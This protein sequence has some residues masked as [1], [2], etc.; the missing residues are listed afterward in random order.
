MMHVLAAAGDGQA[1]RAYVSSMGGEGDVGHE[2]IARGVPGAGAAA[3]AEG[4]VPAHGH[5]QVPCCLQAAICK[6]GDN[7]CLSRHLWGTRPPLTVHLCHH[8]ACALLCSFER[9]QNHY[10]G[11][12]LGAADAMV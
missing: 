8:S 7:R 1:A 5:E 10:T 2:A 4:A 9:L 12:T 3:A 11:G 6:A